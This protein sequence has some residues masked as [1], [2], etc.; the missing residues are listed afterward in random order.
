MGHFASHKSPYISLH[1]L[2]QLSG[3]IHVV[4]HQSRKVLQALGLALL[5]RG[6][7]VG[8]GRGR[9]FVA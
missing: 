3:H 8:K 9:G 6:G 4:P 7:L 1:I 2:H 5:G